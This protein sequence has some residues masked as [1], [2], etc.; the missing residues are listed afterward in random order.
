MFRIARLAC[1]SLLTVASLPL[2]AQEPGTRVT[3]TVSPGFVNFAGYGGG[4]ASAVARLSIS[5]D[6]T[7]TSGGELAAFTVAPL[8]AA[9]IE[10]TCLPEAHCQSITSPSLLSGVM[11]SGYAFLGGTRLRSALGGGFVSASGGRGIAQRSSAALM[12]G[13]DLVP[14]D[15]RGLTPTVG[16]RFLQLT[17]PVAGA[18]QLVLPGIGFTF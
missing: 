8:G 18:R 6:F 14:K 12:V 7:G 11:A 10:P 5:R 4:F 17:R 3:L 16:V 9:S 13:L 15:R 1:A 2:A